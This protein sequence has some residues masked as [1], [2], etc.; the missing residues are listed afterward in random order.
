MAINVGVGSLSSFNT[1]LRKLASEIFWLIEIIE[2]KES[3]TSVEAFAA[4]IASRGNPFNVTGTSFRFTVV[5]PPVNSLAKDKAGT[6]K[7]AAPKAD[8]AAN[9]KKSRRETPLCSS[10]LESSL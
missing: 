7:I 4:A 10:I 3:Y 6:D 5:A 8:P 9:F 1:A 2:E